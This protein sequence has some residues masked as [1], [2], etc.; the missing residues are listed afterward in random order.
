MTTVLIADDHAAI[1]AGLRMILESADDI[2]VVGEAADGAVAMRNARALRPDVVLMDVR[3]PGTDGIEA[4]RALAG[5]GM[6]VLVLTTYDEDEA[7]FGAI[8]AGAAGFLLKTIDAPDLIAAVRR[9]AAGEGAIAP[10]VARRVLA[11][12][13]GEDGAPSS[14]DRADAHRRS[15]AISRLEAAGLTPRER[16]ILGEIGEGASNGQIAQHGGITLGTTKSH[17][18]RILAKLGVSSRTQ[19]A[20][21]ARDA[22]LT[23]FVGGRG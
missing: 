6:A 1:R 19:A 20:L 23:G 9:V 2:E 13:A 5:E 11:A 4:T 8:G 7:V 3:M 17:V 16:A 12:V 15:E 10:A 18:S 22:G 21:L 14:P